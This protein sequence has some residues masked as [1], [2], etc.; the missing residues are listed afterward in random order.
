MAVKLI[1]SQRLLHIPYVLYLQALRQN[2]CD[3][4]KA[5]RSTHYRITSYTARAMGSIY[6]C[7]VDDSASIA[8]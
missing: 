4:L 1:V 5:W 8:L 3:N 6:H 2:N 7:I